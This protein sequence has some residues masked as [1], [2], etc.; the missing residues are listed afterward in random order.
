M[1]A[2]QAVASLLHVF[3]A[4]LAL[5]VAVFLLTLP[6][7][8][9]LRFFLANVLLE[10]TASLTPAG[11]IASVIA[12]LLFCGFFWAHR[13]YYL[14]LRMGS[15]RFAV[16]EK[17][18]WQSIEPELKKRLGDRLELSAIEFNRERDIEFTARINTQSDEELEQVLSS[19]EE[20]L[21][22]LLEERFGYRRPFSL[23]VYRP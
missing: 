19:A 4:L 8:P 3:A 9:E 20:Q 13:G 17:V 18:L 11:I 21:V 12:L 7:V 23:K 10:K 22:V 14:V 15:R 6:H 1:N 5:G 2:K 16:D